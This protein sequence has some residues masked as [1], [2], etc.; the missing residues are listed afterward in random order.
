MKRMGLLKNG[1]IV[2]ETVE[3][4]PKGKP[5]K[6]DDGKPAEGDA[7]TGKPEEGEPKDAGKED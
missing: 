5:A 3:A 2:N 1:K 6:K 4:K 7:K